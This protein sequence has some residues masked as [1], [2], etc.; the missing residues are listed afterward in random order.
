[1][2]LLVGND[3]DKVELQLARETV[4]RSCISLWF[5]LFL[6]EYSLYL[7]SPSWT[8][9]TTQSVD[10][11]RS[12]CK[13]LPQ[14]QICRWMWLRSTCAGRKPLQFSAHKYGNSQKL[15]GGFCY[16]WELLYS[17]CTRI[18]ALHGF[19]YES[20]PCQQKN[21]AANA[22]F[23]TTCTHRTLSSNRTL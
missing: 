10:Q 21:V 19:R 20:P 18:W 3:N 8:F 6:A 4:H 12:S 16:I 11:T 13:Q 9:S 17:G 23:S 5:W 14:L 22:P 15:L 1:M 2:R 7:S